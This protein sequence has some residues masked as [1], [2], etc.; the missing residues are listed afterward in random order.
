MNSLPAV[1]S[2]GQSFRN[3]AFA[4]PYLTREEEHEYAVAVQTNNCPVAARKLLESHFRFVAS[5][6]RKFSNCY[7]VDVDDLIQQGCIGLLNAIKKFCPARYPDIRFVTY[8]KLHIK[9]EILNYVLENVRSYRIA[10]T[11]SQRK[12][13]YNLNKY[14]TGNSHSMSDATVAMVAQD[15][16]VTESEVR[17]M[18]SKLRSEDASL[19]S[20]EGE[21]IQ[22]QLLSSKLDPARIYEE[23]TDE[24]NAIKRIKDAIGTLSERNQSIVYHRLIAEEQ[25]GLRELAEEHGVSVERVRQIESESIV[26]IRK[27][28]AAECK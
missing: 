20:E 5:M 23:I 26:K 17:I 9:S 13:F 25:K 28:I 8:A 21:L 18:E 16:G 11:K 2:V 15:L 14:R 4:A 12:L 19:D 1:M 6:A 7:K 10:T 22:N 3:M 24:T 27:L